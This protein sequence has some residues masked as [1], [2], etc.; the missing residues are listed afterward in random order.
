MDMRTENA[1]SGAGGSR[2]IGALLREAREATGM[3]VAEVSRALRIRQVYVEAIESDDYPSLPGKT[4]VLGFLRSYSDL[5]GLDG[6]DVV[7]RYRRQAEYSGLPQSPLNFPAREMESR[8]PRGAVVVLSL[9]LAGAAIYGG[10]RYFGS[11]DTHRVDRVSPVPDRLIAEARDTTQPVAPPRLDPSSAYAAQM[12]VGA[13][14]LDPSRSTAS[15]TLPAF[16][17]L[18]SVPV[19]Q[20]DSSTVPPAMLSGPGGAPPGSQVAAASPPVPAAQSAPA[21][22]KPLAAKPA[23]KPSEKPPEKP[24]EKPN[25]KLGAKP[26]DKRQTAV[27]PAAN[28]GTSQIASLPPSTDDAAPPKPRDVV[29]V[30][31][32]DSWI[33]V[34]DVSNRPLVSL[35]LRVGDSYRVPS[36][37]NYRLVTGDLRGLEVRVDGVPVPQKGTDDGKVH[38]TLSLDGDR[39]QA[40][41]GMVQ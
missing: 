34:R 35:L 26:D 14:S 8:V 37:A 21:P 38:R 32:V 41:N 30:A 20:I 36:G 7:Q 25:E 5:L 29:V 40:G 3:S 12:P 23:E 10:T 31:R 4:Y 11:N 6:D 18:P 9:A 33:E 13:D 28:A 22:I 19:P 1:T 17:P 16:D 24:P 15:A 39:L 27:A 2:L